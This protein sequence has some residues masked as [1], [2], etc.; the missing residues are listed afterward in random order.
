MNNTFKIN[1]MHCASCSSNVEKIARSFKEIN[2]VSV[3]LLQELITI[4]YANDFDMNKL[5]AKLDDAG[6]ELIINHEIITK[7]FSLKGMSCTACVSAVER[8]LGRFE[9][10]KDVNIQ[11]LMETISISYDRNNIEEWKKALGKADFTLIENSNNRSILL[12]MDMKNLDKAK[13]VL[14]K[15]SG[16]VNPLILKEHLSLSY[17]VSVLKISDIINHLNAEKIEAHYRE[18]AEEVVEKKHYYTIFI[19]LILAAILLYVGM[20]HMIPGIRLPLPNII[21]DRIN[22]QNF[23][24]IQFILT[25]IILYMG[26]GFFTRGIKA[27][28]HLAP[29][30]DSLVAIGTGCAYIYSLF[31]MYQIYNL[32]IHAVHCL[33]FESAGIVVALVQF[34]KHLEAKAKYK[35]T[36]AIQALLKLRPSKATLWINE[37][38]QSVYIDEICKGDIVLCKAGESIPV[39]G[40]IIDGKAY[41]DESL[42]SGE[43]MPK[44][45][46]QNDDV[47]Q[48]SFNMD[49]R[50]L[51]KTKDATDNTTLANII[52][53]VQEAQNKK[54]P[55]ARIADRISKYFVPTVMGIALM[56]AIVWYIINGDLNFALTIF[57]SV[58]LIACPCALGLATPTA[59]MVGSGKGAQMGL[60]IKSGEALET[61]SHIDTIVFDKTGTITVG[62]PQ[63]AKVKSQLESSEAIRIAASLEQGSK[64]PLAHALIDAS[65]NNNT[66]LYSIS[67]SETLNGRGIK[68]T[69]HNKEYYVGSAAFM[70]YTNKS[71][72]QYK[73]E[74]N[75]YLNEGQGVIFLGDNEQ[76]LALF[77]I[78]DGIKKDSKEII[79]KLKNYHYEVILL[80]GDNEI[81]AKVIAKIA[82]IDNVIA[83]VLPNEKGDVITSLQAQGKKVAM[84]GDGI[85]DAIALT[86]S[87]IGIAI[88]S[89]SDVAIE[90]ADVVLMSENI[91]GVFDALMLSKAVL[92]NIKQNLFWAFF[93]NI[94]GIPLAAGL[95]YGFNGLLLSPVFAGF[96]MA[97]SSISVVSNA[98][99]LRFFKQ[100]VK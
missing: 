93:Y 71:I 15:I 2:S 46:S 32:D 97:F 42:L 43:S 22:P 12:A 86:Q 60:F 7:V 58:M 44:T 14:E 34:G 21:D 5:A 95:F 62:K 13:C 26:R 80:S 96:A 61:A 33:Y 63:V 90:S 67:N 25:T 72:N 91:S 38:E 11:L 18:K 68:G 19:S 57:V 4:D 40:E 94:L 59:I 10:I 31:S 89:G 81:S 74:M 75:T 73:D 79:T 92:R 20:S 52:K 76:V 6:F 98:L 66:S 41:I 9:E 69:I 65:V 70:K 82:G 30:M 39:D 53:L 78:S 77:A 35:S 47:Y 100:S 23:A 83:N 55:I 50:L 51:I 56:S 88:G 8:I 85:N 49:G 1:G 64:H 84:V 87:D 37:Q 45:K 36:S 27:L 29:T 24:L 17:D 3:N 54:A 48:G 16:I 99:R 28:I